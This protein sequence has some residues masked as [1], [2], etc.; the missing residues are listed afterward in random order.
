MS[1]EYYIAEY[2]GKFG[3]R[4]ICCDDNGDIV[5]LTEKPKLTYFDYK[6]K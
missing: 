3:T 5:E 2:K 6:E 4:Y 1:K